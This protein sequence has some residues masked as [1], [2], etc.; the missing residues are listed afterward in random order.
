MK[1][2]DIVVRVSVE[3]RESSIDVSSMCER[4]AVSSAVLLEV[5]P[6]EALAEG[7]VGLVFHPE[8]IK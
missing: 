7:V 6:P 8:K 2:G 4:A 3:P 5:L 1:N